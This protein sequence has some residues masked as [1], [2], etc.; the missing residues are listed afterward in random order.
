[1]QCRQGYRFL[2]THTRYQVPWWAFASCGVGVIVYQLLDAFDGI[3]AS[4]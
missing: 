2:L 3:Q 4:A 1:M